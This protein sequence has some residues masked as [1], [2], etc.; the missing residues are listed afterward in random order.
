MG[1]IYMGAIG[2]DVGKT[3]D[4]T[5]NRGR[6]GSKFKPCWAG[7]CMLVNVSDGFFREYGGTEGSGVKEGTWCLEY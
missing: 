4:N 2:M 6:K 7:I 5:Y 1:V 3:P